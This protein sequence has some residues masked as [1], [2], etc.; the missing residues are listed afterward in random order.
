MRMIRDTINQW[1]SIQ[2]ETALLFVYKLKCASGYVDR[3]RYERL[4]RARAC[5]QAD[6][7]RSIFQQTFCVAFL[8]ISI[9][10]ILATTFEFVQILV[11]V[12][13]F[14]VE[15]HRCISTHLVFPRTNPLT[16]VLII[17]SCLYYKPTSDISNNV[18]LGVARLYYSRNLLLLVFRRFFVR[19]DIRS[20]FYNSC[21]WIKRI[22][23]TPS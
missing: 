5:A 3:C 1:D 21:P 7:I 6:A 20:K 16:C 23:I 13:P 15:A 4:P 19:Y 8:L 12:E 22:K 18:R 11:V 2:P 17:L 14:E 10:Y 9:L